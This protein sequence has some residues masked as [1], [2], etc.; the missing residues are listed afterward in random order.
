MDIHKLNKLELLSYKD[1]EGNLFN[2]GFHSKV[3]QSVDGL[4]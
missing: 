3:Q 4:L 2:A 1:F